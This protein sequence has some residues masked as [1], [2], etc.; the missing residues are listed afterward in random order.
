MNFL[1]PREIA[2]LQR[3]LIWPLKATC[4]SS[5]CTVP[6]PSTCA[7]MDVEN[8]VRTRKE[9]ENTETENIYE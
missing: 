9:D 3:T 7:Q 2:H 1:G 8:P 4:K 5:A 6:S